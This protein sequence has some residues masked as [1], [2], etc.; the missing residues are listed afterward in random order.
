MIRR[1]RLHGLV[2]LWC[3]IKLSGECFLSSL[4]PEPS[5]MVEVEVISGG[6]NEGAGDVRPI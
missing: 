4:Y 2:F 5:V 6:S 1:T 3:L